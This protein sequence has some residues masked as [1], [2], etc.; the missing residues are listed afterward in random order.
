MTT[1]TAAPAKT[2]VP[3]RAAPVGSIID[4]M[5]AKREEKRKLE[6][7]LK[8]VEQDLEEISEELSARMDAEGVK[9]ATGSAASVSFTYS[10]AADVQGEEGW[11][12][13]FPYIAKKKYWGLLRKQL[14]DTSYREIL[15]VLNHQNPAEL[16]P[17]KCK[18][19]LPGVLPFTKKRI[20]LRALTT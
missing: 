1:A 12:Q 20:N 19:H 16:D 11:A 4:R 2:R 8:K 5:W 9:K 7:D 6:A 13:I 15:A 3:V 18:V 17:T 14:N 10:I